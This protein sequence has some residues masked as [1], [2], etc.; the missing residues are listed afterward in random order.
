MNII[1]DFSCTQE[2][3]IV[4]WNF[5]STQIV[6]KFDAKVFAECFKEKDGVIVVVR[7][8]K[9]FPNNAIIFNPD[10]SKRTTVINPL[11]EKGDFGFS[12]VFYIKDEIALISTGNLRQHSCII[13]KNGNILK[14]SEFR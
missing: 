11:A 8:K 4:R 12:D 1:S 9:S 13:D 10:G 3:E 7:S 14:I 2:D 5:D 6:K